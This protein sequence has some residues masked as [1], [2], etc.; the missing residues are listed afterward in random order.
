[1]ELNHKPSKAAPK[2]A[3]CSGGLLVYRGQKLKFPP[4]ALLGPGP[5]GCLL[6]RAAANGRFGSKT[7]A[8]ISTC[9]WEPEKTLRT[10]VLY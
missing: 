8:A 1:M 7:E 3:V 4:L 5:V 10:Q 9:I 6:A 2:K